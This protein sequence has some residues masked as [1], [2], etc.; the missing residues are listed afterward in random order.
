MEK[1]ATR[2]VKKKEKM[3]FKN[4]DALQSVTNVLNEAACALNETS[5]TIKQS[6]IPEV[7]FGAIG[8]GIG[9]AGS[10]IA[11]YSLGVPGLSAAGVISGLTAAGGGVSAVLGGAVSAT[12]AG[13]AVIAA[14][15]VVVTGI[16][17]GVVAHVKNKHLQQEKEALYKEALQK[18]AAI[19]KALKE[20]VNADRERIDYLQ[21]LNIL[22]TKAI[23]DLQKDLGVAS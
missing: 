12:A 18:Q 22:L 9:G 14:P 20:E 16:G 2:V 5:R 11:L 21:S 10:F 23:K 7:L 19:I 6:A 17:V 3:I 15:A 8:A 13:V 1:K 4:K